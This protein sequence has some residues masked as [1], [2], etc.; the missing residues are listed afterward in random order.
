SVRSLS[1]RHVKAIVRS[2]G[3]SISKKI[4][5]CQSPKAGSPATTGIAWDV[6]DESFESYWNRD[7]VA[8]GGNDYDYPATRVHSIFGGKDQTGAVANGLE[9]LS[10]MSDAGSPMISF[11]TI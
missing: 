5:R 6:A 2:F 9:V 7:S 3:S 4:S 1:H 11:E 8:T 10:T